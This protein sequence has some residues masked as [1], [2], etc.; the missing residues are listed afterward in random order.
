MKSKYGFSD[1]TIEIETGKFVEHHRAKGR[2]PAGPV[3]A[4]HLWMTRQ[5]EFVGGPEKER[6]KREAE[7]RELN[8]RINRQVEDA[9]AEANACDP[10]EALAAIQQVKQTLRPPPDDEVVI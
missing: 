5:W 8:E 4:W 6:K 3:G 10:E 7:E 1:S 9:W 2:S